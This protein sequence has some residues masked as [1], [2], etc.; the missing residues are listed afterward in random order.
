MNHLKIWYFAVVRNCLL[1]E[2]R[3]IFKLPSLR[4]RDD[5][6]TGSFIETKLVDHMV[7]KT[8]V[9]NLIL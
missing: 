6:Y 7:I 8:H 9:V 1:Q 4:Y 2:H 3:Q 5:V